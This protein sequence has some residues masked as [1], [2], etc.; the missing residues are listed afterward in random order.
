MELNIDKFR[1]RAN[2]LAG[3]AQEALRVYNYLL[4][5]KEEQGKNDDRTKDNENITETKPEGD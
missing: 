3:Q 5:L 2:I 1:D 4:A